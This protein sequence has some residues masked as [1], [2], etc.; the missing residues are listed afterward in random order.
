[1]EE[2]III[3]SIKSAGGAVQSI[4][5]VLIMIFGLI[6][7]ISFFSNSTR[8]G[9]SFEYY[10]SRESEL[11]ALCRIAAAAL[12]VASFVYSMVFVKGS[13]TATNKRIY[14]TAESD[15]KV[16]LPLEAITAVEGSKINDSVIVTTTTGVIKF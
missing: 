4:F 11:A 3:K 12:L 6:P 14:G 16:D 1:M 9:N 7:F 8:Y 2:K 5:N 13:I 10:L 15:V